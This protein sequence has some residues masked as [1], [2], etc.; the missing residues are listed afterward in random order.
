M[1]ENKLIWMLVI[2]IKECLYVKV[3]LSFCNVIF[4]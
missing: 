2:L 4:L 1:K 3:Y